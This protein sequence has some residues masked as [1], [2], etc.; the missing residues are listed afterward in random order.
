[1][2]VWAAIPAKLT[3]HFDQAGDPEIH[4]VSAEQWEVEVARKARQD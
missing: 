3:N 1:M 4:I 2:L